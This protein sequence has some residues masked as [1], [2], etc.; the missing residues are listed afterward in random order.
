[1]LFTRLLL[2]ASF[3][4]LGACHV[5]FGDS[6]RFHED[7][8]HSFKVTP[9]AS[10]LAIE[11][12]N[13][14][15]DISTWDK[16][17]IE[18]NGTKKAASEDLLK[19]IKIN[20]D[21]TPNAVRIR[22]DRPN[23]G[24]GNCGVRFAI[25]V[26]KKLELEKIKSSN[27]GIQVTGVEGPANLHTSNGRIEAIRMNGKL[28][29]ETTNGSIDLDG[30]RGLVQAR[31]SNGKIAGEIAKGWLDAHTSN[32]GIDV[33]LSEIDS[34]EPVKL[35]TSNGNI[36]V[37]MKSAHALRARTSNSSITVKLPEKIDAN[38]RARTSNSRVETDFVD[39]RKSSGD[40]D[41]DDDNKHKTLD[42]KVGNG[43]PLIDLSTSNGNIRII[44]QI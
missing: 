42:A 15:I 32:G 4:L 14:E 41:E 9:G 35:E 2:A 34:Q 13:G 43:G 17:E 11:N 24:N 40:G 1:M 18:I 38:L 20:I 3:A 37:A 33:Q 7:F 26:P 16:D 6:D 8:H 10:R 27:G 23:F 25:R 12:Q 39:M 31:T 28:V 21:A 30:H 29:V 5:D 22:V 44:K 19:S 36:T